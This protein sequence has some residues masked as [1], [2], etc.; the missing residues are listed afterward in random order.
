[1]LDLEEQRS[2]DVGKDTTEGDGGTDQSVQFL[3]TTD[4]EL[5]MSW[6]DTL[7]LEILGSVACEFKDFG[8]EVLQ[9]G[10]DI[11]GSCLPELDFATFEL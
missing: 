5:E 2:V 11:D 10:G 1:M 3:I 8:S 9:D 4:G 7:D 6:S